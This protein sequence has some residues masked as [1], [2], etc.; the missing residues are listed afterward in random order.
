[1]YFASILQEQGTSRDGMFDFVT[2]S[3]EKK[4]DFLL[5]CLMICEQQLLEGH[6]NI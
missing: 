1:M 3:E 2:C 6:Q 5:L 4:Q